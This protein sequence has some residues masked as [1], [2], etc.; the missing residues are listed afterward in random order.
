[1]ATIWKPFLVG[2][3][4]AGVTCSALGY[5]LVSTLWRLSVARQARNKK[6]KRQQGIATEM[7][8]S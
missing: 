2:S 6:K 7:Q 8:E 3:L 1:M 4:I 5:F